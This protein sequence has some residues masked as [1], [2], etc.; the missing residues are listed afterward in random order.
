MTAGGFF[1]MDRL[2]CTAAGMD[3]CL[4]KPFSIRQLGEAVSKVLSRGG[5]MDTL[6]DTISAGTD[7][8]AGFHSGVILDDRPSSAALSV[9]DEEDFDRHYR[10]APDLARE[11]LGLFLAQTRPLFESARDAAGRGDW[12]V[13]EDAMHRMKGSA[14]AIEAPRL[15]MM[16]SEIHDAAKEAAGGPHGAQSSAAGIAALLDA[17]GSTLAELEGR[18]SGYLARL[19]QAGSQDLGGGAL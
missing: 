1:Y 9:F 19:G 8:K 13:V 17:Y 14:G 3:D 11:I 15:S 12:A 5:K 2:R 10:Q 18:L 6:G 4:V 16:A 7:G